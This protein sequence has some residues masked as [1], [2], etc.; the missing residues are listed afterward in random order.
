MFIDVGVGTSDLLLIQV[1]LNL[2]VMEKVG[3]LLYT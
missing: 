3:Q 1:C 2:L